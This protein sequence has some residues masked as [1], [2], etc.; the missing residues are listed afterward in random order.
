MV[1]SF[2]LDL[3]S[4][5]IGFFMPAYMNF[6]T[7]NQKPQRKQH[8][9]VQ[10]RIQLVLLPSPSVHHLHFSI[11]DQVTLK[12]C[13]FQINF[14]KYWTVYA[15]YTVADT[16]AHTFYLTC[17][18]G[19]TVSGIVEFQKMSSNRLFDFHWVV[20]LNWRCFL[21][22]PSWFIG[23]PSDCCNLIIINATISARKTGLLVLHFSIVHERIDQILRPGVFYHFSLAFGYSK[24]RRRVFFMGPSSLLNFNCFIM[25]TILQ[26]LTPFVLKHESEIDSL[27]GRLLQYG[28]YTAKAAI[29]GQ[30]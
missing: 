23:W 21:L 13:T 12:R 25:E 17:I 2:L 11:S 7:I 14:N 4:S 3:A 1:L 29:G 9:I 10:V 30:F 20:T 19:Y 28:F 6:K 18:P 5:V 22:V 26:V 8:Q 24:N 15:L 16:V 27:M